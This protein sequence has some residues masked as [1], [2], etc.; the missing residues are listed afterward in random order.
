MNTILGLGFILL[1]ALFSARLIN[2][3]RFP[4]VTAYL[5]LGILIGPSLLNIVPEGILGFSGQLSNI[6]LGMI[7][8]SIGQNFSRDNFRKVGKSVLWISVLEVCVTWVLVTLAFVLILKQPFY[9][10]LLFG[11]IAPATAPAATV[12]VI[13]EYRTKGN[14]TDTLMGVIA[15]DDAWGLIVF[16]LSLAIAQAISAQSSATSFLI[17]VL[18]SSLLSI[19][20]A[21]VLG[22]VMAILLSYLSRFVRTQT[23]LLIFTLGF[24]FLNIGISVWLGFSVLLANMFMGTILVNINKFSFKFFDSL[25]TIDSPLYLLFFT[26]AGASLEVGIISK[27][28]LIG[29]IY[30]IF[31]MLGQVIGAIWG[32][33]ISHATA[34]VKKY[35]GLGLF[36]QAGVAVGCALI[37]KN[38]FPAAGG[39]IFT[40]IIATTVIFE[41][42]GPL[43]TKYALYKAGEIP[44]EQSQNE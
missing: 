9:I 16:A 34:C 35:L 37:V 41:I 26:M 40:T 39:M 38:D 24:V 28:G 15:I 21:F 6:V 14:F 2:K 17:R 22:T 44:V 8:F 19:G 36:P 30:I 23:E 43:C 10:A 25:K 33:Y 27:L 11:A 32:A 3:I 20:G 1:A 42:I 5:V 13:R 18:L 7:A 29:L 31:R 4:A 12:M